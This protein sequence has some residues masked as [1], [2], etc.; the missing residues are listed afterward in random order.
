MEKKK[1]V[2][3]LPSVSYVN[4]HPGTQAVTLLFSVILLLRD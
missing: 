3:L 2:I 1:K 4:F